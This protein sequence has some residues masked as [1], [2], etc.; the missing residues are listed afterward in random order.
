MKLFVF[1]LILLSISCTRQLDENMSINLDLSAFNKASES[2]SS[3]AVPS[4]YYPAHLVANIHYDGKTAVKE[5]DCDHNTAITNCQ[6]PSAINF[7]QNFPN[8]TGRVIQVLLVF[9]NEDENLSFF[10]SHKLNVTFQGGALQVTLNTWEDAGTSAGIATVAGK[11]GTSPLGPTGILIGSY[12]P[13][14]PAGYTE[15]QIPSVKI[16]KEYIM[17]GWFNI[18][19]FRGKKFTYKLYDDNMVFVR[20]I[21]YQKQFEDFESQVTTTKAA[22][23]I[24][25]PER[26]EVHPNSSSA[27]ESHKIQSEDVVIGFF[28]NNTLNIVNRDIDAN[29]ANDFEVSVRL[30]GGP[31]SYPDNYV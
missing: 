16:F 10:Y 30:A 25:L 22:T 15:A 18:E 7:S 11:I 13:N 6:F 20:N 17:G 29:S 3:Q 24:R 1:G 9:Q 12:E 5:W 23:H 4:G 26:Y 27:W 19:F 31:I 14:R 8:G 2:L 21:F 28:D